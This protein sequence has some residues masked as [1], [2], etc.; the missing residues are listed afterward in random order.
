MTYEANRKSIQGFFS[1][2]FSG[3]AANKIAWDNVDF[4]IPDDESAWV[5]CSVQHN[6]SNFVSFGPNRRTR[7]LGIVFIQIFVPENSETLIASQLT[8]NVVD[9]FE[10][11]S[12]GGVVFESPDV[13]EAGVTRGWYQVNISVP[14]YFDDITTVT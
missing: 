6:G 2:N 9:V 4:T 1:S 10:T 12:L 14:F 8:D 13:R 5:R 11:N 7:R 3:V